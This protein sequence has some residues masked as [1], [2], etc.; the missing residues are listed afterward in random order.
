MAVSILC[1]QT[2]PLPSSPPLSF[3]TPPRLFARSRRLFSWLFLRP[4]S[5]FTGYSARRVVLHISASLNLNVCLHKKG[6]YRRRTT[7][8]TTTTTTAT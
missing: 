5:L 6:P 7:I 4:E 8:T 2:L 3:P 1:Q